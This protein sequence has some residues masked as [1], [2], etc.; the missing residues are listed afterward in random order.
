MKNDIK[1]EE[2]KKQKWKS[3]EPHNA[4]STYSSP[5]EFQIN[6]KQDKMIDIQNYYAQITPILTMDCQLVSSAVDSNENEWCCC[7]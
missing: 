2:R 5:I 6:R 1:K 3:N 4:L 7:F